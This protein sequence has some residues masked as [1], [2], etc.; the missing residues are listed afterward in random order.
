MYRDLWITELDSEVQNAMECWFG[1]TQRCHPT[2]Q[3]S[4][5]FDAITRVQVQI[6]GVRQQLSNASRGMGNQA[7]DW[8]YLCVN[9]NLW[10]G[11]LVRVVSESGGS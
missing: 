3:S 10:R 11:V 2:I 9:W 6:G 5:S 7:M 1:V 4:R 8:V